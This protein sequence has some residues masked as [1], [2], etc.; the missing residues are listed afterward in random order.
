[1]G[2]SSGM[3]YIH[4]LESL[5]SSIF[6]GRGSFSLSLPPYDQYHALRINQINGQFL[7]FARLY[8]G[9]IARRNRGHRHRRRAR[10]AS[11][12]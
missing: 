4:K 5:L 11:V 8:P 7:F 1:V 9:R 6:L 3:I 10:G 12:H 2:T